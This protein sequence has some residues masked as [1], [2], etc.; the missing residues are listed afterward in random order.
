LSAILPVYVLLSTP[1][2]LLRYGNVLRDPRLAKDYLPM[3]KLPL[4][5][6]LRAAHFIYL[7]NL[8]PEF[9]DRASPDDRGE[10]VRSVRFWSRGME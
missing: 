6:K 7:D 8:I 10:L 5:E 2:F 3:D 4:S 9:Q 1:Y